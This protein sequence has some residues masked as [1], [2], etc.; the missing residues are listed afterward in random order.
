MAEQR[1]YCSIGRIKNK[2]NLGLL[3]VLETLRDQHNER[4]NHYLKFREEN[5]KEGTERHG[6]YTGLIVACETTR[7]W[8]KDM[9]E[10][11]FSKPNDQA[12]S[13]GRKG[14]SEAG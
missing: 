8:A 2:M 10:V 6:Y 4:A 13:S 3:E 11:Y 9:I 7:D 5:Y 1:V 14:F 12:E